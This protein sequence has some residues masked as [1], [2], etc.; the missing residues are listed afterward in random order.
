[1]DYERPEDAFP[2]VRSPMEDQTPPFEVFWTRVGL[3]TEVLKGCNIQ[4]GQLL[5]FWS[6]MHLILA[7][8]IDSKKHIK[9]CSIA[10]AKLMLLVE[11]RTLVDLAMYVFMTRQAKALSYELSALPYGLL[12][13]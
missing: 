5:S 9:N 6:I 13:T 8:Y 2:V 10:Q 1:M 11:H 7:Y 3:D 12:L 4:Y